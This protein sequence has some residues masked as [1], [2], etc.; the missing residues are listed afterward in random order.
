MI[1]PANFECRVG[2]DKIRDEIV[3]LCSMESA[4]ELIAAEGFTRS[5]REVEARLQ[6]ADEMRLLISLEHGADVGEQ[7]DI[8]ATVEKIAVEGSYLVE[9]EALAMLG[10]LR[11]VSSIVSFILSRL[12]FFVRII[13]KTTPQSRALPQGLLY[14]HAGA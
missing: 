1:Y 12:S 10:A 9:A 5:M 2:F 13:S 4:R 6:L 11:S 8:R 14:H 3:G 7:Q